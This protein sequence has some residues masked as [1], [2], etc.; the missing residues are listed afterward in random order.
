[1]NA[2]KTNQPQ[3]T[4]PIFYFF[5]DDTTSASKDMADFK[6]CCADRVFCLVIDDRHYNVHRY[7][8][9]KFIQDEKL[10]PIGLDVRR[11]TFWSPL[12]C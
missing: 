11:K 6:H 3:L 2:K 8:E 4:P 9:L 1:M 10:R 7:A 12:R 5:A